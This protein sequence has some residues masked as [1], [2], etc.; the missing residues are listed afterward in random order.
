[1]HG[2]FTGAQYI[3][4]SEELATLR[5]TQITLHDDIRQLK[6]KSSSETSGRREAQNE[7]EKSLCVRPALDERTLQCHEVSPINHNVE[8]RIVKISL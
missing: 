2:V 7:T 1:M 4:Q 6:A 3:S 5:D 8:V